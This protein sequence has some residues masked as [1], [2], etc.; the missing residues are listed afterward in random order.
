MASGFTVLFGAP[1]GGTFFALEILH[2]QNVVEYFEAILP[3]VVASCA[4]YTI[5]VAITQLGIGPTWHFP[6]YNLDSLYDFGAAIAYGIVGAI[7]GWLFIAVF[8][9]CGTE[10]G[11]KDLS[12]RI[13]NCSNCDYITDRDVA[14]A[15]V[16][17]IRGLA[18][19]GHTACDA[20]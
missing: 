7:V 10:T 8:R 11:K 1:L 16:V 5:F 15:Q 2:H 13:H 6:Q 4:I 9:N 3:A 20:C 19:V 18:A 17:L 14:S 12:E